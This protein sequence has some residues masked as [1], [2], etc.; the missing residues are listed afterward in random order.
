[1]T[2]AD[3]V[4]PAAFGG[5]PHHFLVVRED[6]RCRANKRAYQ[7]L[8]A[9]KSLTATP[10]KRTSTSI[11]S[12]SP[13]CAQSAAVIPSEIPSGPWSCTLRMTLCCITPYVCTYTY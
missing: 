8:A 7:A 6:V 9:L 2:I 11:R 13:F 4:E 10:A 12:M 3:D 5:L 1:M